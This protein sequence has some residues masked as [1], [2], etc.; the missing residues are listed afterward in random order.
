MKCPL[1]GF[2]YNEEDGIK[3]CAGCPMSR[4]KCK[5]QRCPN[6]GYEIPLEPKL[7]KFLKKLGKKDKDES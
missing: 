2:E 1:C 3:A 5:F 6:C 7:I 4:G